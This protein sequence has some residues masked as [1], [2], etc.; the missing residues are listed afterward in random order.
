MT[1]RACQAA[2]VTELLRT[3]IL[4]ADTQSAEPSE[5][6]GVT[7]LTVAVQEM[8]ADRCRPQAQMLP[9]RKGEAWFSRPS[10]ASPRC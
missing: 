6:P 1:M 2:A 3:R 10:W 4:A 5:R 7:A 8:L 9:A